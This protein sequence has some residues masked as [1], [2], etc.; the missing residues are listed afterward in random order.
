MGKILF[1][2]NLIYL[3]LIAIIYCTKK[4]Q[5]TEDNKLYKIILITSIIGLIIDMLQYIAI[6]KAYP[7][8]IIKGLNK[9]FLIYVIIWIT[10]FAQ[11]I[12]NIGNKKQTKEQ[13]DRIKIIS[14]C[15]IIILLL[16]P[17]NAQMMNNQGIY[18]YGLSVDLCHVVSIGYIL[19]MFLIMIKDIYILQEN[20]LKKYI[21]LFLY[22]ILTS[23]SL[24]TQVKVPYLLLTTSVHTFVTVVTFFFIENPDIELIEQLEIAKEQADRANEAKTDFLSSMSHEIRTPLNAIVG[25]SDC[26]ENA[27]TIEEAKNNAKDIVKASDTLLEIVNGI[28]DIS[29]IEA[30]KVG[31]VNTP[32]SS[33]EF[34]T[35]IAKEIEPKIKEKGIE[36][37]YYIANDLPKTLYGDDTNLKKIMMNI[38]KNAYK[39]T[40]TGFI[41]YEVN[42]INIKDICKLIIT[43]EDSGK[44]IKKEEMDGLFTKFERQKEDKN[45]TIEGTGL[46][47]AI[48]KELIELMGGRIIVHS[49]Y[50]EGSKFTII[51][52]QKIQAENQKNITIQKEI[53]LSKVKILIVDDNKLNLKVATKLLER[54]NA[55]EIT[56]IESGFECIEKM[57]QKEVY[58]LILLDD[59]MPEMSGVETLKKLKKISGF[60]IPVVMLTANAI[61]GMREKYLYDGFD[62]YISK[63]I[64]KDQLVQVLSSILKE[65]IE[66]EK[67]TKE[68][69][70]QEENQKDSLQEKKEI[71]PKEFLKLKGVDIDQALEL[72][73]DMNL[74][75]DTVK[76]F[77]EELEQ[78]WKRIIEYKEKGNMKDYAIEVHS[79]KSDA[80]YLGLTKLA[81]I[82]YD[83]ELKSKEE[84]KNY[85]HDHWEELE[86][87]KHQSIE[88]LHSYLAL[89]QEDTK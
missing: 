34:F 85:I 36:F 1:I 78:K 70:Q 50:K 28:L 51:V 88:I 58:D 41:R 30:G 64:Q 42:C 87:E 33:K 3:T 61:H 13:L 56:C 59:M 14:L 54:L 6:E 20:E 27:K 79:L 45:T 63:P 60:K 69:S 62:D 66:V 11:Y 4:K 86:K 81:E 55:K 24:I 5:N 75:K 21:P 74:Y 17:V 47:L 2:F 8:I 19:I 37:T 7:I 25:F 15:F 57:K 31:I 46:G 38:L 35:S 10:I 48:S 16:L 71:S 26:L 65:K 49:T 84:D 43:V 18:I 67:S 32:Y 9:L 22:A 72:L 76:D 73:G 68:K 44:G 40:K 82:A 12:L 52:N 53:D 80:K 23:I 29:K 83:H 39:Y 89:D 77:I